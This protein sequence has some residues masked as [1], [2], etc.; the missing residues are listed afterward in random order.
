M[1]SEKTRLSLLTF[2]ED[3]EEEMVAMQKEQDDLINFDDQVAAG[4]NES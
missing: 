1:I 3:P 4:N 2:I